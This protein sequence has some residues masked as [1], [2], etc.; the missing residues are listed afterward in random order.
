MVFF[1]R[2]PLAWAEEHIAAWLAPSLTIFQDTVGA[3][4]R[5]IGSLYAW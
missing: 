1:E 4:E 3:S 5:R 2:V